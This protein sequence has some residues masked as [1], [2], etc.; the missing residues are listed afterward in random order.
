MYNCGRADSLMH[1]K[2]L[3][4]DCIYI[5]IVKS[6]SA[7]GHRSLPLYDAISSVKCRQPPVYMCRM[8][9][10]TAKYISRES[11]SQTVVISG[12]AITA[13]SKPSLL[14]KSGRL[15]PTIFAIIIVPRS[16][17]DTTRAIRNAFGSL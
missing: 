2:S 5:V 8:L 16:V 13:G 15:P 11:E 12:L 6:P 9:V 1:R 17:S 7:I 10:A 4:P 14:A 3:A